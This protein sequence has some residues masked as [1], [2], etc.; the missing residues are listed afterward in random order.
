MNNNYEQE[1]KNLQEERNNEFRQLERY[2]NVIHGEQ[3][4]TKISQE[5]SSKAKITAIEELY[6][7]SCSTILSKNTFSQ[8]IADSK[9]ELKAILDN[10]NLPLKQRIEYREVYSL[11]DQVQKKLNN[12]DKITNAFLAKNLAE[13]I[14]VVLDNTL[15]NKEKL[16]KKQLIIKKNYNRTS[17]FLRKNTYKDI[18]SI[19]MKISQTVNYYIEESINKIKRNV[20]KLHSNKEE[21]KKLNIFLKIKKVFNKL[22][23]ASLFTVLIGDKANKTI[24]N[25][26]PVEKVKE[27][28]SEQFN[29]DFN[30]TFDFN[31]PTL[32]QNKK[33]SI[34]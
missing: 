22:A 5:Q 2:L 12:D 18:S 1:L 16:N 24:D 21:S 34:S 31:E 3:I 8:D 6:N 19:S 20:N 25:N 26:E 7:P 23:N 11:I 10:N 27:I 33:F 30:K 32:K 17:L 14:N 4:L 13:Y 29:S 28:I 9:S 15:S